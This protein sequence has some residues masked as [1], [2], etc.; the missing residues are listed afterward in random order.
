MIRKIFPDIVL[1]I[2]MISIFFLHQQ[3]QAQGEG[4]STTQAIS[5]MK[6][7]TPGLKTVGVLCNSEKNDVLLKKIQK[8]ATILGVTVVLLN[9]KSMSDYSSQY[10][11]AMAAQHLDFLWVPTMDDLILGAFGKEFLFRNTVLDKVP[12]MVPSS[13]LTAEGG[14]CNVQL[15]DGSLEIVL[16]KKLA[17]YY[18]VNVPEA[19]VEKVKY[20]AN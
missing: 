8:S 13:D 12:L 17:Q 10:R 11:S 6:I 2:V 9:I 14:L 18:Q 20:V 15:K 7:F 4:A 16:N 1:F 5:V 19:Y 3:L